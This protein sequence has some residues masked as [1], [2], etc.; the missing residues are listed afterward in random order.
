MSRQEAIEKIAL[1]AY[2]R[3]TIAEDFEYVATKLD[4]TV[5][6]LRAIMA[7]PNK[8]YHDYRNSMGLIELGT[9][10]LRAFGVQRAIIR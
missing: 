4:L 7:G 8:S 5:Q 9:K 3:A 2:E 1:P 10:V 6:E